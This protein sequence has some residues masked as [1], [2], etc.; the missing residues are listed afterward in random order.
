M[1]MRAI[2]R[3]RS[4]T[5]FSSDRSRSRSINAVF[6]SSTASSLAFSSPIFIEGRSSHCFSSRDPMPVTVSSSTPSSVLERDPSS[7]STSSRLRTVVESS[8]R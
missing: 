8:I 3:S 1:L 2:N 6:N 4:A 5:F 7:A